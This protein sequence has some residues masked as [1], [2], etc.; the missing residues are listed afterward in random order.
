MTGATPPDPCR[1]ALAIA[2]AA[3]PVLRYRLMAI[4]T[5][6][7]PPDPCGARRRAADAA[8]LPLF[9]ED[10]AFVGEFGDVAVVSK[11][12]QDAF[13]IDI[14]SVGLFS[15]AKIDGVI[16]LEGSE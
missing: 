5:N 16:Y 8:S 9:P 11:L 12:V 6:H 7:T 3:L 10:V 15:C 1:S 14:P 2:L 13:C 4:I